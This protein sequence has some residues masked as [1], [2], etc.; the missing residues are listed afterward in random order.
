M[1]T[2]HKL[3]DGGGIMYIWITVVWHI[4]FIVTPP[5]PTKKISSKKKKKV[6]CSYLE[7]KCQD[8]E[9][10]ALD[11]GSIKM[12]FCEEKKITIDVC[13]IKLM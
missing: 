3:G 7:K 10:I 8:W 4:I 5:I 2:C 12:Y 9:G 6:F 11:H 1:A 13:Y